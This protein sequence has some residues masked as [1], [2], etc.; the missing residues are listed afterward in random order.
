MLFGLPWVAAGVATPN[1]GG[2]K[3]FGEVDVLIHYTQPPGATQLD[4]VRANGG[5]VYRTFNIVPAVAAR[6]PH[7]A[8]AAIRR[9]VEVVSIDPD[10]EVLAHSEL[11]AAWGEVRIGCVAVHAGTFPG[12]TGPVL[13][14]GVKVAILDTGIDYLHPDLA[15]NYAGGFDFVNGDEDPM[16]DNGHGTHV[17]GTVAAAQDGIGMIGIAPSASLYALKVLGANGSGNWSGI[18][19]A[20]D[21][22][23]SH[24]VSVVNLSLGSA[25]DPGLT[26]RTAFDNAAGA[27]IF[28]VASAG[29]AGPGTDTVNYPARFFR[30][31]SRFDNHLGRT[32]GFFQHG[33]DC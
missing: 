1:G 26:V 7:S 27:G 33:P 30:D 3:G 10:S 17:S 4:E 6:V 21:W 14:A 2:G 15:P 5:V 31:R 24:G 8:L 20:L 13:G 9:K 29:N 22:V 32:V 11:D 19:A 12:A 23:V 16:D 28:M 25:T 18:I